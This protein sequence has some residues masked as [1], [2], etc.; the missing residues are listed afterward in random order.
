[1][2]TEL[3]AY[4]SIYQALILAVAVFWITHWWGR[5][6]SENIALGQWIVS[7]LLIMLAKTLPLWLF[8][9]LIKPGQIKAV[10]YLTFA[11]LFYG[12][13]AVM[14]LLSGYWL[15]GLVQLMVISWLF[16]LTLVLGRQVK[17]AAKAQQ[18]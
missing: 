14:N 7:G 10:N 18:S 6:P 13:V 5:S 17:K 12:L 3:K 9:F 1:M 8:L 4:R 11:C 16:W 2:N 15:V